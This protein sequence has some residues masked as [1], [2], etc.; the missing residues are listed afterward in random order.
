MMSRSISLIIALPCMSLYVYRCVRSNAAAR[1]DYDNAVNE[2]TNYQIQQVHG[3]DHMS[4]ALAS[5]A[6]TW[7]MRASLEEDGQRPSTT[8]AKGPKFERP[9]QVHTT[10]TTSQCSLL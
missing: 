10:T 5:A 4:D 6:D 3:R 2:L 1:D 9:D 8:V 7:Q